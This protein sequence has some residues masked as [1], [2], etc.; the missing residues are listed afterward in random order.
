M[1]PPGRILDDPRFLDEAL[2]WQRILARLD[3][4]HDERADAVIATDLRGIVVY[5]N[6]AAERLY[7]WSR[8]EVIGHAITELTVGPEDEQVAERVMT[9]LRDAG[10]WEGDFWVRRKDGTRFLAHVADS[11]E[12]DA[13]GAPAVLVGVSRPAGGGG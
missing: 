7:G 3:A 12:P 1:S 6:A 9:A 4:E 5:W 8:D 11:M 13:E 10:R 2:R